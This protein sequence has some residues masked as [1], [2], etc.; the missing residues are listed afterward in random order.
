MTTIPYSACVDCT[1][2]SPF[3]CTLAKATDQHHERASTARLA[4]RHCTARFRPL[5]LKAR[6]FWMDYTEDSYCH[7]YTICGLS[8]EDSN[9]HPN[10]V[11]IVFGACAA[12]VVKNS[13]LV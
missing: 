1:E 8:T 10:P 12:C 11:W 7:L 6:S 13:T 3:R 4:T 9:C 5:A 2:D